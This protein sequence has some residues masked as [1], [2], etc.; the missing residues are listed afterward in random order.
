MSR[1]QGFQF[2]KLRLGNL[3]ARRDWGHARDYVQAMHLMV[4]QKKP[5]DYVIAT[6]NTYSIR[7]FLDEAFSLIDVWDWSN[8]VVVDPKFYR[9]AEVEY[10]QGKP[11]KARDQLSWIPEIEFKQLVQIMVEHDIHAA[12]KLE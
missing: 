6:G 7:Q 11:D 5:E 10:L 2:A 12:Q 8:Y 3:D 4:Q 1:D 9:P